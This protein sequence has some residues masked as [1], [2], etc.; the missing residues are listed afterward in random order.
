MPR[1]QLISL[2]ALS[3]VFIACGTSSDSQVNDEGSGEESTSS[4]DFSSSDAG[5]RSS[6]SDV[7]G[8]ADGGTSERNSTEGDERHVPACERDEDCG[9]ADLVC[10]CLGVCEDVSGQ[11]PCTEPK[12]CGSGAWCDPCVGH[13][14]DEASLC[15]PCTAAGL[16][17]AT[18]AC[19]SAEQAG[20]ADQGVCIPF[21][22]GGS[23]CG[24]ACLSAAGCPNGYA[25]SEV[26]GASEKQCVP[27][28]G[29]CTDLGLC[30]DDAGCPE[31][32]VCLEGPQV[33]GPGCLDDAGCPNGQV[34]DQAR[35]VE[36][37]LS[38]AECTAPELC[39]EG[40]HC[41]DPNACESWT[42]CPP[43]HYCHKS[44]GQCVPG[45]QLD[46]QC[47]DASKVCEE[48]ACVPKGCEHNYQ[49]AFEEECTQESGA[50]EP[51]ARPHCS[52]CDASAD[53][54]A[55]CQGEPNICVT[56]QDDEGS[57]VGDFCLLTCES[58][59]I[60]ACPQGYSCQE[61]EAPDAGIS[62][63]YCVRQCWQEPF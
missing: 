5:T 55:Q 58:D 7:Q 28:S 1:I 35:C 57:E 20:C 6:E 23:F 53:D 59:P 30:E 44:D 13:C 45:C 16:C 49:C 8:S 36:P 61:I 24:M 52:T 25:C 17:D 46:E 10:S 2:C 32:Q 31:G 14:R 37:C 19:R 47:A 3:S 50:C 34:C 4:A 21:A 60:D 51:M 42:E 22:S 41:K 26:D 56:F 48:G 38:D 63:Y 11:N 43:V 54:P 9:G 62:G 33:C 12:N 40:G 27:T 15:E 39:D 18:G 29:Q